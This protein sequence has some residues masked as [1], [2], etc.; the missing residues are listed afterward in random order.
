[1]LVLRG[2]RASGT[3]YTQARDPRRA[4]YDGFPPDSAAVA[5]ATGLGAR[6]IAALAPTLDSLAGHRA[7][8]L[9]PA[10]LQRRRLRRDRFAHPRR[11]LHARVRGAASAGSRSGTRTP[12]SDSL[13][14]RKSPAELALLR[15]AIDVTVAA[16]REAMRAVRPGHVGV[17]D[18]GAVHL[19]VP[20]R[21]AAT[22]RRSAPSSARVR[23]RPS[24]TTRRNNRRM[25]AGRRRGDG[26]RR[27]LERATRPT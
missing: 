21:P 11:G 2:G 13:R 10:R 5:R 27:R 22:G 6:S 18:R 16:Q 20:A 12:S 9:H 1:M 14:A 8:V 17:R 24:T 4:L 15:R 26:R 19:R 23:T 3:L 7:A 25:R